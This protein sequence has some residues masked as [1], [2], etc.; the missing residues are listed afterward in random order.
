MTVETKNP[1]VVGINEGWTNPSDVL[2]SANN[3][4]AY[5]SGWVEVYTVKL[6]AHTYGFNIP[7]NAIINSLKFGVKIATS[8]VWFT[9]IFTYGEIKNTRTNITWGTDE[10]I[11]NPS[12]CSAS[13]WKETPE[14][15]SYFTVDDLNNENFTTCVIARNALAE[16]FG[17]HY[18]DAMRIVV[19]YSVPVAVPKVFGDGFTWVSAVRKTYKDF[20]RLLGMWGVE[21]RCL[22]RLRKL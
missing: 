13:V 7:A 2:G 22:L 14:L 19:D 5:Y 1:S 3:I 12:S 20:K 8:Q 9:S 6:Y 15:A 17:D 10:V 4:C 18:C 16:W 21:E 11:N